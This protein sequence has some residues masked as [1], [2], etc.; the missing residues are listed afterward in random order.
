MNNT[1]RII[2]IAIDPSPDSGSTSVVYALCNDGTVWSRVDIP[3]KQ[4]SQMD[5]VPQPQEV[6]RG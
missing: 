3:G 4:W 6:A 2:Q 5:D 1:R